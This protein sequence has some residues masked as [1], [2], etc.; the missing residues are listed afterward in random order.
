MMGAAGLFKLSEGAVKAGHDTYLLST[1]LHTSTGEAG[2]LKRAFSLVDADATMVI[3]IFARLGKQ[4]TNVGENGNALTEAMSNYDFTLTDSAGRMLSYTQMLGELAKGYKNAQEAGETTEFVSNVLGARGTNLEPLLANYESL[5]AASKDV[6]TTGLLDPQ[7]AEIAY[8]ELKRLEFETGQLKSAMGASL[9]PITRELMPEIV[10]GFKGMVGFISENKEGLNSFG[11][12]A[13]DVFGGTAR[14]IGGVIAGLGDLKSAMGDI[15]GSTEAE[16]ILKNAGLDDYLKTGSTTGMILGGMLGSRFG[17]QGAVIGGIAGGELGEGIYS[18]VGKGYLKLTGEWDYYQQKAQLMEQEKKAWADLKKIRADL[19]DDWDETG[20]LTARQKRVA[21]IQKNLENEMANATS[22]R[23]KDKIADIEET[24]K[25]SIEAGVKEA[26]AWKKAEKEIAKAITETRAEAEKANEELKQSIY[27]LTH[28]DLENKF[29]KVDLQSEKLLNSGADADLVN[30]NANLQMQ[31]IREEFNRD[32]VSKVNESYQ[33]D[34]QNKLQAIEQ[35]KQAYIQKGL[36]EV[37]ANR[38][39]ENEKAKTIRDFNN[40]VAANLDSIW[41][42]ELEK[43][44]AQIEREKQ[45]WILS[46][47]PL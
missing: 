1:R 24:T 13:G 17:A 28:N 33:T 8:R 18:L 44:L 5:I 36:E 31:K 27:E 22:Q 4:M 15:S 19:G 26:T 3:P 16:K 34:L 39:A 30:Q 47:N 37:E 43:R 32:V 7:S 29:D 46:V 42:N 20:D 25:Q 12:I 40:E 9:L 10:S 14:L 45:A 23:L 35:E 6:K 11:Q 2:Q 41:Q 21:E 38:W